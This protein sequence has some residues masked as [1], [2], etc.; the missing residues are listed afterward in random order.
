MSNWI[1]AL[2]EKAKIGFKTHTNFNS[3]I[4]FGTDITTFI[5]QVKNLNEQHWLPKLV[6]KT[7]TNE[8]ELPTWATLPCE[9]PMHEHKKSKTPNISTTNEI[10]KQTKQE[11][12]EIASNNCAVFTILLLTN[13]TL[14][15]H[16]KT[17]VKAIPTDFKKIDID[18]LFLMNKWITPHGLPI[19]TQSKTNTTTTDIKK[20]LD[21]GLSLLVSVPE[22]TTIWY[23]ETC[24][25][26]KTPHTISLHKI[27]N[28]YWMI[29][30]NGTAPLKK[31]MFHNLIKAALSTNGIIIGVTT[32]MLDTTEM[33]QRLYS[34][35]CENYPQTTIYNARQNKEYPNTKRTELMAIP[36]TNEI[37]ISL[38]T[39][40]PPLNLFSYINEHLA[41]INNNHNFI[42]SETNVT[43]TSHIHL[44]NDETQPEQEMAMPNMIFESLIPTQNTYNTSDEYQF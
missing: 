24:I 22:N 11:M 37:D 12:N 33:T 29:D 38:K 1:W 41:I 13:L 19:Y 14:H 17:F 9:T 40:E 27:Q 42:V 4:L 21:D 28:V 8:F 43:N 2:G 34:I 31:D 39:L 26:T 15:T 20:W 5:N 10:I 36:D 3:N 30:I 6:I 18:M 23:N 44:M 7:K 32:T 16:G 25:Q 35:I